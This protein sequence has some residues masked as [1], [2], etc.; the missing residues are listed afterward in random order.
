MNTIFLLPY[1]GAS[2]STFRSYVERFPRDTGRVVPVEL[3]GRGKRLHEASAES[4]EACAALTLQQIDTTCGDYILHGHC[5]GALLAFEAIKLIEASGGRLPSFM[6][7]SGRNAPRHVNAWLRRVVELDDH[8]FLKELQNIGGVPRGLSYAMAQQFLALIRNDQAMARHYDPG[9]T[10]IDVPILV[11][12]GRDDPMTNAAALA[13]WQ[14]YTS[15][16]LSIE[17]MD[18][19]HHFILGQPDRVAMHVEAFAKSLECPARCPERAA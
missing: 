7:A 11:L 6:V 15:K 19:Q 5:M 3:P 8:G 13:D 12:A 18:G 2:A 4:I 17:W 9:V 16:R 10:R 14:H 1:G